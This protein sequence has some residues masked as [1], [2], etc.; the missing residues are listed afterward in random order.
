MEKILEKYMDDDGYIRELDKLAVELVRVSDID[1][2]FETI[3]KV[4]DNNKIILNKLKDENRKLSQ[5]KKEDNY[6]YVEKNYRSVPRMPKKKVIKTEKE[7][8]DICFYTDFI[9]E[10]KDT[11]LY[12][13]ILPRDN[14]KENLAIIDR[15][16]SHYLKEKVLLEYLIVSDSN[17]D[18]YIEELTII[19]NIFNVIKEYKEGLLVSTDVSE[20]IDNI[21]YYCDNDG[22]PYIYKDI[23]D[24]EESYE[25]IKELMESLKNRTFKNLKSFTDNEKIKGLFE[26][27][28]LNSNCNNRVLF[29]FLGN[30]KICV[31]GA[32][33]NKKETNKI[34]RSRLQKR[35]QNY[36]NNIDKIIGESL[37]NY[38]KK[39]FKGDNNE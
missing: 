18:D 12:L 26:V 17:V 33:I 28:S 11:D 34:Y 31:I 38:I 10:N 29:T 14:T 21:V 5:Y 36:K 25:S 6:I 30:H 32:I 4:K 2:V 20:S 39:L 15:I 13:E 9:D 35:Y 16:L 8:I 27:R 37:D 7:K 23:E 1:L 22:I 24:E 3:K 19:D